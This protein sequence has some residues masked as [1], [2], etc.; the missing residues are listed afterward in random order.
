[1]QGAL[2]VICGLVNRFNKYSTYFSDN[3]GLEP[4]IRA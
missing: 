1:M 3:P 4:Y 2:Q